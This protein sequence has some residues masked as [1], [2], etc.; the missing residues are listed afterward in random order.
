MGPEAMFT[1]GKFIAL[2]AFTLVVVGAIPDPIVPEAELLQQSYEDATATLAQLKAAGK[3]DKACRDLSKTAIKE[4]QDSVNTAQSQINSLSDG[5]S[6]SKAG[7]ELVSAAEGDLKAAN[8]RATDAQNAA[9]NAA[10]A[11]GDFGSIP[12]DQMKPGK[13]GT[14]LDKSAYK[15]A[16]SKRDAAERE[17][18]RAK[19]EAEGAKKAL[20]SARREAAKLKKYCECKA[21]HTANKA[22]D[23]AAASNS[24]NAKAWTKGKHMACVLD[25]VSPSKCSVGTIPKVSRRKMAN[26]SINNSACHEE[27]KDIK[28][29]EAADERK[30]KDEAKKKLTCTVNTKSSNKAGVI[31]P[32][33]KSGW[34]LTGCGMHNKYR[35]WNKLAG[36]EEM[37]PD[38]SHCRCDTGFGNAKLS[39]GYTM[40]GGG[41]VNN[42]RSWNKQAGFEESRPTGNNWRADMGFGK[43]DF[44]SYVTGCKGLSCRTGSKRSSGGN[45]NCPSGYQVTGCGVNN[46]HRNWDKKSG[47]EDVRPSGNGCFCD[48]GFGTGDNTCY[49][50]CC[51]GT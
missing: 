36:F 48:T 37:R 16:V 34:S 25:G 7:Q 23:A 19:G 13:C 41:S 27:H 4:V 24:A 9:N 11:K 49:A 47:F 20:D 18:L 42:Y 22:Y 12:L 39:S 26:G 28:N 15:N 10:N 40:T 31:K 1:M 30:A 17:A 14:F 3:D 45:V 50:R 35:S 38:G 46:H 51:K 33:G 44:K 2:A 8:K 43:G 32:S 5:S 6:C 29:K 21:L